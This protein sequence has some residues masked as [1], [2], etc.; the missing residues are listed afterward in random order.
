[1]FHGK[2]TPSSTLAS[3]F[4][5]KP[6][7]L[8]WFLTMFVNEH[9]QIMTQYWYVK[10]KHEEYGISYVGDRKPKLNIK[11]TLTTDYDETWDVTST[12]NSFLLNYH[13]N[14]KVRQQ[15]KCKSDSFVH[16]QGYTY[17][18]TW[19]TCRLKIIIQRI[20]VVN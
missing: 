13:A 6:L 1:M 16:W 20:W 9:D 4:S 18:E 11:Y 5:K 19:V 17:F 3:P 2:T 10:E 7:C 8:V 15:Q 14:T 12:K